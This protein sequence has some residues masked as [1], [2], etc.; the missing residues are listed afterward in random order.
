MG[1]ISITWTLPVAVASWKVFPW[2]LPVN[3][4]PKK[5]EACV[6]SFRLTDEKICFLIF[7]QAASVGRGS[8]R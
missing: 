7:K 4:R 6:S 3:R 5:L 2:R 8:E 1:Y